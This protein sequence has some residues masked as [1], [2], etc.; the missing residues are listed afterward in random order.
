[1]EQNNFLRL[2]AGM[3]DARNRARWAEDS[4]YYSYDTPIHCLYHLFD[5]LHGL[6]GSV[7]EVN[8]WCLMQLFITR[9][10]TAAWYEKSTTEKDMYAILGQSMFEIDEKHI[11]EIVSALSIDSPDTYHLTRGEVVEEWRL[12]CSRGGEL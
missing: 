10:F 3:T 12:Y 7:K 9:P 8:V 2:P 1:M 4:G 6:R 5:I 11:F